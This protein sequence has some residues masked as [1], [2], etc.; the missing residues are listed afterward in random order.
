MIVEDELVTAMGIGSLITDMNYET[1]KIVNSGE[2]AIKQVEIDNPDL[3]LMDITLDGK[4][5]GIDTAAEIL[6][7]RD[8]PIIFIT[9]HEDIETLQKAKNV[10]PSSYIIKP[11]QTVNDLRP[12]IELAFH[13]FDIKQQLKQSDQKLSFI[14]NLI[15]TDG[16]NE[17]NSDN[18]HTTKAKRNQISPKSYSEKD[19]KG[20]VGKLEVLANSDRFLILDVLKTRQ[21]KLRD[22]QKLIKKSQSTSSHH[23]KKL[24]NE[25]FIKGW[26]KGKFTF[27]SI[28]KEELHKFLD[29][30]NA[31][32]QIKNI[33]EK[34]EH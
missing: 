24:E 3:L 29:L 33:N 16:L 2:D 13:N 9:A 14:K 1:L 31:W 21:L 4:M 7:N 32:I 6:K 30:W 20:L 25:G 34:G 5:D 18:N 26:K 12:A 11:I 17:K 23:I 28:D 22:I 15:K 10:D 8:I 19:F 27:Y